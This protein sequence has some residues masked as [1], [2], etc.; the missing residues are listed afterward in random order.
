MD[1]DLY[2]QMSF[3]A[4]CPQLACSTHIGICQSDTESSN[5][6]LMRRY[7]D[8]VALF[9]HNTFVDAGST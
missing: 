7:L 3:A 1:N 9:A 6:T 4:V 8:A 2:T 5:E